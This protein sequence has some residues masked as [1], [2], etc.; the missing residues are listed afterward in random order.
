VSSRVHQLL[1]YARRRGHAP[2]GPLRA[3]DGE[4]LDRIFAVG[5]KQLERL[6]KEIELRT[7]C[8]LE[9]RT[10]LDFGCGRGRIAIPLAARCAHVYGLDVRP[11]IL[12]QA[13][14]NAKLQRVENVEW[15][16]A[17]RLSEL[18]GRYDAVV[19]L[20]VFQHIPSREGERILATLLDGMRPGGVGAIHFVLRPG[21][22]VLRWLRWMRART[23]RNPFNVLRQL[24]WSYSYLS[25]GSYS[26]NRV[27]RIFAGCGI[28]DWH[29]NWHSR[30]GPIDAVTIIF[31]KAAP[32]TP[33]RVS[34][35]HAAGVASPS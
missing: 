13:D 17:A 12:A 15:L 22:P 24:Y 16:D 28:T 3:P 14:R 35:Q 31:H 4:A 30:S 23:S 21:D 7:R 25:M 2:K 10:A 1:I 9:S 32:A 34:D 19:S 29:T 27:A 33:T 8:S 6:A 18:K 20:F 11:G 5:E 26:L